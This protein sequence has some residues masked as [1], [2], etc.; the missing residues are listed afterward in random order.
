MK[1]FQM[2]AVEGQKSRPMK[3]GL[4]AAVFLHQHYPDQ[5]QRSDSEFYCEKESPS[6]PGTS[7]LPAL[8]Y[9]Y[10]FGYL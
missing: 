4:I 10:D 3:D 1:V 8:R 6:Q 7:E 9:F 5:V 2:G